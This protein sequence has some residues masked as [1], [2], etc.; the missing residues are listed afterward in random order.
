[1]MSSIKTDQNKDDSNKNNFSLRPKI[2]E[3]VKPHTTEV[4]DEEKE[5]EDKIIDNYE[6]IPN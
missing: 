4:N 5:Q 6:Q 3:L 1:M 2:L